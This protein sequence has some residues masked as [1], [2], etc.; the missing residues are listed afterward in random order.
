[1][2]PGPTGMDFRRVIMTLL[3]RDCCWDLLVIVN[4]VGMIVNI[5]LQRSPAAASPALTE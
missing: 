1:V 2:E 5:P 3:L 4:D